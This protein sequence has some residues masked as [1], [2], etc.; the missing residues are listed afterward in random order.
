MTKPVTLNSGKAKAET[1]KA[2]PNPRIINQPK[3]KSRQEQLKTLLSRKNGATS[4]KIQTAFGWQP[5]R[6]RAAVCSLRKA[7]EG[8][9][10]FKTPGGTAYR[11]VPAVAAK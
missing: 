7:G 2:K 3:R 1:S 9:E 11:I 8:I 10:K 5:H 4:D 6:V